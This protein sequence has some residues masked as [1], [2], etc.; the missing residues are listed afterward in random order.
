[1]QCATPHAMTRIERVRCNMIRSR[2][3]PGKHSFTVISVCAKR[4]WNVC[5]YRHNILTWYKVP[6]K[7]AMHVRRIA[8]IR[9]LNIMRHI[10]EHHARPSNLSQKKS[11]ALTLRHSQIHAPITIPHAILHAAAC[12][13][14]DSW[15]LKQTIFACC[16]ILSASISLHPTV[17]NTPL[18][19]NATRCLQGRFL[20]I[21]LRTS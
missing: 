12:H 6:R 17:R 20:Q 11:G 13:Q 15:F 7:Y 9:I 3:M 10:F 21:S 19:S 2:S 1:M 8:Q 14:S 16:A 4:S 18:R 5:V